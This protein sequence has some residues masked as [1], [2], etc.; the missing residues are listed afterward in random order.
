M[1]VAG[2]QLTDRI[3]AG[4]KSEVDVRV[5]QPRQQCRAAEI[6]DLQTSARA[7]PQSTETIVEP[8][9][10]TIGSTTSPDPL[11][12]NSL[13]A[14]RTIKAESRLHAAAVVSC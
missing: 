3:D 8:S 1:V 4:V 2:R 5:D 10:R 11:P 6:D 13:A 14:R 12:S 7:T 9:M